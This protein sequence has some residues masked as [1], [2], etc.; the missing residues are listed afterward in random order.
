MNI[1]I[2]LDPSSN[3]DLEQYV[4]FLNSINGIMLHLDVMDGAFVKRI[5][6][7]KDEYDFTITNTDHM[8]DVHLM[9]ENPQDKINPFIAKAIWGRIKSVSF[10]IEATPSTDIAVALLKKVRTMKVQAG[11]VIDLPTMI[12]SVPEQVFTMTDV[13]TVMSVNCGESGRPFD[14]SALKKVRS[15]K[16]KY[17]HI[18]IILDGGIKPEHIEAVK[19]AGVDTAVFGSYIYKATDRAEAISAL[20]KA[21]E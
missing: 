11:I 5:S 13:V 20:Q 2:S 9:I 6:M 18:R 3:K 8:A 19:K 17:P 16:A 7:H 1:S 4:K 14:E 12:E 15:I 10:H 21:L